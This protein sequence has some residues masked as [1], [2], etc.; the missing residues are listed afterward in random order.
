MGT[1]S[2]HRFAE[3]MKTIGSVVALGLTFAATHVVAQ[4]T[5]QSIYR[6]ISTDVTCDA[7]RALT[8]AGWRGARRP[9]VRPN[10]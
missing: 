9:S 2:T 1:L 3:A 6:Q 8:L 4:T 7:D 10:Y 5:Q